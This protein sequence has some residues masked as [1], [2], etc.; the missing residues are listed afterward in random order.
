MKMSSR[1]GFTVF[2]LVVAVSIAALIAYFAFSFS[3]SL[4]DIWGSTSSKVE[5]ELDAN[6]ALDVIAQDLEAAVFLENQGTMFAATA[7]A[8]N[9]SGSNLDDRTVS[10]RWE[11]VG[12]GD[13][14]R[15]ADN[16]FYPEFPKG[17]TITEGEEPPDYEPVHSYGWA[18]MWVRFFTA[19]PSLNAVS[20]QIIRRGTF[21]GSE[22]NAETRYVLHRAVVRNGNTQESGFDIQHSNYTVL[23]GVQVSEGD[24]ISV[25]SPTLPS[26]L[27]ENVVDFGVRLYV[28]EKISNPPNYFPPGMQLIYP[29]FSEGSAEPESRSY[30][31][32]T[33]EA[34]QDGNDDERYPDAVEVFL[35]VLSE[36]GARLL[37]ESE[38][39]DGRKTFEEIVAEHSSLFRR[40]VIINDRIPVESPEA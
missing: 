24:A 19:A 8:K 26:Y 13:K 35:R 25:V 28:Y 32:G 22:R 3:R 27:I 4:L 2:E 12:N 17:W 40:F 36:R 34:P 7:L 9:G 14:E 31:A 11:D 5:L 38:E 18:G 29:V 16:D 1:R 37:S 23:A 10:G 33:F 21:S 30:F 15:A 39:G 20:Y 6:F